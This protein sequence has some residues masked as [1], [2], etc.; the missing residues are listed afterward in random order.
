MQE[1]WSE[2]WFWF[3]GGRESTEA[4]ERSKPTLAPPAATASLVLIWVCARRRRRRGAS[5][6]GVINGLVYN[7]TYGGLYVFMNNAHVVFEKV[8][9]KIVDKSM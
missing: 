8:V 4:V 6:F 9:T 1:A 3:C 7:P 2:L 5:A